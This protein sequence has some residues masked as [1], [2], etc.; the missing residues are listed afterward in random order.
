MTSLKHL[1]LGTCAATLLAPAFIAG[2]AHAEA[3]KALPFNTEQKAALEDFVRDFILE[4]PE[5]IIE[6]VNRYKVKE[7]QKQDQDAISSLSKYKDFIYNN[8]DIPQTGNPKADI[9]IVEFFDF[10]CGYCHRAF[11]GIQQTLTE[12][13]NVRFVFID[14]PILSEQSNLATEWALA[15]QKQGKYYEFHKAVMTFNGPKTVE[16]LTDLA[17]K[18]GLDVEKIKK[19]AAGEDVQ[20][21]LAKHSEIAQAMRISGTPGFIVG[22]QIIRGYLPYEDMKTVIASI[23]KGDKKE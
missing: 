22:D 17:K 6:A 18:T 23:R 2:Q 11:D 13:K 1:I 15:A 8:K 14:L 21:A 5:V 10:N 12:D 7:E 20:A 16:T 9:T 19:D 4:N 3:A